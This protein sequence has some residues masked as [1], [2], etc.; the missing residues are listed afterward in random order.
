MCAQEWRKFPVYTHGEGASAVKVHMEVRRDMRGMFSQ[1]L[2]A[3]QARS[4]MVLLDMSP[5]YA[6]C[7]QALLAALWSVTC[8]LRAAEARKLPGGNT[9][10][11]RS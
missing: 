5:A 1:L 9:C 8:F 10:H 2:S 6:V 3:R 7:S 4:A 11:N